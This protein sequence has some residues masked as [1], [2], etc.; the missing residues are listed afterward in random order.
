MRIGL[1]G[2][3]ATA[4]RIVEQ[5][6]AAEADGFTSLWYASAVFGDPLVAMAL[7][8]QAGHAP[9]A[10]RGRLGRI[11]VKIETISRDPGDCPI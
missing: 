8:G 9:A 2:G 3:G 11:T 5:A 7:A 10:T 6:V 1:P 4:E